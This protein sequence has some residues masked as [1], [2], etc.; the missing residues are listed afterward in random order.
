LIVAVGA[1]LGCGG[2]HYAVVASAASSRLEEAKALG[3]EQFA[4]Y[5][6]YFAREHLQQ[7]EVEA[8]EAS[9]SDAVHLAQEADEHASSAIAL[10][11]KAR[12]VRP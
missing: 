3:A 4:P 7:A 8:A 10:T 11:Q 9:Y 1:Q 5:E 12:R 2:V 6:Y